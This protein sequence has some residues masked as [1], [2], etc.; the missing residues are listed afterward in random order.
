[1]ENI[2]LQLVA[3]KITILSYTTVIIE[4]KNVVTR[5]ILEK[6]SISNEDAEI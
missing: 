2:L 4:K 5:K 3:Y 1:M 6:R